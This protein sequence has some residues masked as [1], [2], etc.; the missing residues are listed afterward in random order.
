MCFI[1]VI[2]HQ[3]I[4]ESGGQDQSV[5]DIRHKKDVSCTNVDTILYK[6]DDRNDMKLSK[7]LPEV[8]EKYLEKSFESKL[9][10][11]S[12]VESVEKHSVDRRNDLCEANN[13][14]GSAVV[15]SFEDCRNNVQIIKKM[16]SIDKSPNLHEEITPSSDHTYEETNDNILEIRIIQNEEYDQEVPNLVSEVEKVREVNDDTES[17]GYVVFSSQSDTGSLDES[18]QFVEQRQLDSCVS[19]VHVVPNIYIEE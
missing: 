5:P 18:E 8:P 6:E 4:M 11:H 12:D 9:L 15:T 10:E 2:T 1:D 7:R 14:D 3:S 19:E 13:A 16:L 17:D